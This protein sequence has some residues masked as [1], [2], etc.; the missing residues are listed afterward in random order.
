[1]SVNRT[2]VRIRSLSS[3]STA[4]NERALANSML[5]TSTSPTTQAS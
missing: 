1:M 2:V 5:V 3:S 4:P